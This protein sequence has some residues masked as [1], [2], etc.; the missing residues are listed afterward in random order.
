[1]ISLFDS[2]FPTMRTVYVVSD[3]QLNELKV[4]QA[5][6]ELESLETQRA[7]LT[8][9]YESRLEAINARVVDVNAQIKAI[10]PAT[11]TSE[12]TPAAA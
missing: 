1:M 5:Q 10:A 2:Y 9:M 6:E 11:E 4:K 7:S 12:P 8:A 3:S